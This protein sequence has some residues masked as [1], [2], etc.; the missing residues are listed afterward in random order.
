VGK[1]GCFVIVLIL[2]IVVVL[3]WLLV[4]KP[5]EEGASFIMRT[6]TMDDNME[7][8][9][10]NRY[11]KLK[12]SIEEHF[13]DK[14]ESCVTKEISETEMRGHKW[15]E[16]AFACYVNNHTVYL[17]LRG[18]L[19]RSDTYNICER[20]KK[21]EPWLQTAV[22]SNFDIIA[23]R[24]GTPQDIISQILGVCNSVSM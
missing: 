3:F 14:G 2:A 10:I 6:E 5:G 21:D 20:I 7:Q 23:F 11:A 9:L 17:T 13:R 19:S 15:F 8:F 18:H 24:T 1:M 16:M 22:S 12:L 4:I